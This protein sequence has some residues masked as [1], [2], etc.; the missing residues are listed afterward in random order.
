MSEERSRILSLLADGKITVDEAERLLD[1]VGSGAGAGAGAAGEA[2]GKAAGG[3]EAKP[4]ADAGSPPRYMYVKVVSTSGDN[5]DVR[6]PLSLVKSGLKLTSLIPPQAMEQIN[7][8][9][10]EHG[11]TFDFNNFKPED[12]EELIQALREMEVNVDSQNGDNVRVYCA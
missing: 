5:V 11:M 6:I 2:G 1:A 12:I 3:A 7:E 4:S 9:M 8:S 10:G